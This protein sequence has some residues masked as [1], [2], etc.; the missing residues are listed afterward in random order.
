MDENN[1]DYASEDGILYTKD[2]RTLVRC[3]AARRRRVRVH[4]GVRHVA[5]SAFEWCTLLEGVDLPSSV[6]VIDQLAFSKCYS[7]VAVVLPEGLTAIKREA[8]AGCHSLQLVTFPYSLLRIGYKA[9]YKCHRLMD[10]RLPKRLVR[11]GDMAFSDC[12]ALKEVALP[13]SIEELGENVFWRCASMRRAEIPDVLKT[14]AE[15]QKLFN[16]PICHE[17][18]LN[19]KHRLYLRLRNGLQ[20][21]QLHS[22]SHGLR[23]RSSGAARDIS[24]GCPPSGLNRR[25]KLSHR[26]RGQKSTR[27]GY[28]LTPPVLS[29]RIALAPPIPVAN[30]PS[31]SP[32]AVPTA[33][34]KTERPLS[35]NRKL[36]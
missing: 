15:K 21:F 36:P 7:L 13:E 33:S 22:L 14:K 27:R 34:L 20:D 31:R 32:F 26:W 35:S 6:T 19:P 12:S 1:R 5:V 30:T 11:I 16:V 3:P 24:T 25:A 4:D 17:C 28:G 8:F 29:I 23:R 9:F 18:R 10:I 2:F